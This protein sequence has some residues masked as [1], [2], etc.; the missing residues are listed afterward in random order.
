VQVKVFYYYCELPLGPKVLPCKDFSSEHQPQF[1]P[2][3]LI[4][5]QK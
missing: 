1:T 3:L 5:T 4:L 2:R